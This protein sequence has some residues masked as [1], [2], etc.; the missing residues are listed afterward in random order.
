MSEAN[1]R[2]ISHYIVEYE[3][4]N[5][6]YNITVNDGK[7]VTT[8]Q[9]DNFSDVNDIIDKYRKKSEYDM[10]MSTE[11]SFILGV[12]LGIVDHYASILN[13]PSEILNIITRNAY[14]STGY[15]GD[16]I[17]SMEICRFHILISIWRSQLESQKDLISLIYAFRNFSFSYDVRDFPCAV[18]VKLFEHLARLSSSIDIHCIDGDLY[19]DNRDPFTK[20]FL[21]RNFENAIITVVG[22]KPRINID[23]EMFSD[24]KYLNL[25]RIEVTRELY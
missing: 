1:R 14:M 15:S 8:T 18:D 10:S 24:K 7:S 6:I 12:D 21:L 4:I 11:N 3:F 2:I 17:A 16:A 5:G 23:W 9:K 22:F 19:I 20:T 13:T 25:A